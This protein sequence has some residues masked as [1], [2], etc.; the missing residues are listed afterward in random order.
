MGLVFTGSVTALFEELGLGIPYYTP[1][2]RK[3]KAMDCVRQIERGGGTK[4]SKWLLL[5]EPTMELFKLPAPH[6]TRYS[7]SRGAKLMMEQQLRDLGRRVSSLE[8][9]AR[10][11]G[12]RG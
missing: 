4:P 7:Q 8:A 3:L 9:W 6:Q 5:Q 12:W 2:M 1:V 11:N 10:N